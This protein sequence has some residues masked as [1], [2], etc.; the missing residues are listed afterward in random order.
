MILICFVLLLL[1]IIAFFFFFRSHHDA[2][3][4]PT[5]FLGFLEL[6]FVFVFVFLFLMCVPHTH[7]SGNEKKNGE[8]CLSVVF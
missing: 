8:K 3:I 4:S 5:F 2:L 6:F 1:Y 7:L